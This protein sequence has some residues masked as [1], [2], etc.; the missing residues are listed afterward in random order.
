MSTSTKLAPAFVSSVIE[1]G[2]AAF[3]GQR[4]RPVAAYT[5]DGVAVVCCRRTARK[6]GWTVIGRLF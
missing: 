3:D 1:A 5:Q 6:Y 4:K 2:D